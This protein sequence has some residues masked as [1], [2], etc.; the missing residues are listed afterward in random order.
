MPRKVLVVVQFTA[1]ITLI[2]GTIVVFKQIQY[3]KDRPVGYTRDGLVSIPV[4]GD[5]IHKQYE[6]VKDELLKTG[7][8][9]SMAEGDVPPTTGA[10]STSAIKWRD[11][12]PNLSVDFQQAGVAFDYGKTAGWQ[13]R[14]GRDFSNQ[15]LT[16]S[17]A[18]VVNEAA[19]KFMGMKNP[20]TENVTYYGNQ[21]KIIGVIKDI[22]TDSPYGQVKPAVFFLNKGAGGT[23]LLRIK[24]QVSANAA[25]EKIEPIFKQF[26]P[27]Q[28]FQY[29]FVDELYA[30]KFGD[31]QRIGQLAAF[32]AGLAIFISCL[33]LFG[34]ASF[35]AEQRI[36]EIGVRKVLGASVF[37]LWRLLST[38][39]VAL[40]LIALIIAS[41]VAWY[42]MH[43][44]L[45]HFDYRSSISG[46]I[47]VLTG[48]G[49]LFITLITVSFQSIKAALAN[50]IRSL[51]TE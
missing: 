12:D 22:I 51:K 43:G 25:I 16:D 11:K 14:E 13:F 5:A 46:W 23:I 28:P 32:F 20:L 10:G 8:I 48:A 15:F 49:A 41:P 47:F 6:S 1:S 3:A 7:A 36:K 37:N 50:P 9:V 29:N 42:L 45:Q 17:A 30:R 19:I 31:E 26:N 27:D 2:I 34:M 24:P 44:W 40:V 18:V 4:G 21:F 38:D 35:M 33:G 39:F